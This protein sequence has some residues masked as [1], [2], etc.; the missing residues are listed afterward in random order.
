MTWLLPIPVIAPLLAAGLSLVLGRFRRTQLSVTVIALAGSLAAAIAMAF[1]ADTA[2]MVLDVGSW[3]APVGVSLVA[4]RLTLMMLIVS[5][6]VTVG[7]LIYSSSQSVSRDESASPMPVYYPSYLVLSAGVSDAFLAGD[8]F[9]LYIGFEILLA[10]SFVLIT[11]GGTRSR[12]RSGTVYVVVSL[13]SSA[14]FLIGIAFTYAAVGTVNMA[15]LAIRLS[16][17]PEPTRILLQATFLVA[18]GIKAAI[19]PLSAWLP[20]S[21]PTAPAPVT[22]VFAGLLTKV[23]VYAIIRTQ[24][25]LFPGGALDTILAVLGMFTMI[26]GIL[27]AIAQDDIKRMVSFTLVSHIGFMVWGI[28]LSSEAGLGAA[29]VYAAHHIL[30]Q[31]T[32]FLIVG[33]MQYLG[34]TTSLA[35]L[36]GLAGKSPLLAGMFLIVAFNLVGIPPLTGFLGKVGLA[37]ASVLAGTGRGWALLAAGLVASMLTLYVVVKAWSMA[38]WQPSEGEE[39]PKVEKRSLPKA[40]V[41]ATAGLLLVQVAMAG[42]MNIIYGYAERAA[43]DLK[44][45]TP[46]LSAVLGQDGRGSGHSSDVVRR[47]DFD[48]RPPQAQRPQVLPAPLRLDFDTDTRERVRVGENQ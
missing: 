37:R 25:L 41:A 36:G 48:V 19:F 6:I 5:L 15:Q 39:A 44:A 1:E 45:R 47:S 8:L 4:D 7:V 32:L 30:V 9:N 29:I 42:G 46:Y 35:K 10:A 22:A 2:P 13:F 18:F 21:Y 26:V 31:T 27:G 16:E 23:G 34:G 12:V 20:D 38:F 28:S 33:L 43:V 40:M 14:V 17:L 24:F 11:L 3:A